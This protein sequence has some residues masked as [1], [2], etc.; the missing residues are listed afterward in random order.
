MDQL[1]SDV[2]LFCDGPQ[3]RESKLDLI[4]KFEKVWLESDIR[5]EFVPAG[6]ENER[7][8]FDTSFDVLRMNVED[9]VY[10]D[11]KA[12]M[13]NLMDDISQIGKSIEA[14]TAK[15]R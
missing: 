13:Q 6:L 8:C 11:S 4:L 14:T 10:S 2:E 9:G 15:N 7:I 1:I 3:T 5:K 12:G